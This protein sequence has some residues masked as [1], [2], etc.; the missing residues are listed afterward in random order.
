MTQTDFRRKERSARIIGATATV[1]FH[2]VLLLVCISAGVKVHYPPEQ[3]TGLLLDFTQ[4][5]YTELMNFK[6]TPDSE[7]TYEYSNSLYDQISM[8]TELAASLSKIFLWVGVVMAAFAMLLLFNFITNLSQTNHSS[9][10]ISLN[11]SDGMISYLS[12]LNI[13]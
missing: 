4:E 2:A 12:T 10:N 6:T 1:L 13:F 9:E 8:Y 3:Q 11:F 5:E 7:S